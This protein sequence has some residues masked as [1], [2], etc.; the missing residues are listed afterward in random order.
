MDSVSLIIAI[1]HQIEPCFSV[2]DAGRLPVL[3]V[4]FVAS[5]D[6]SAGSLPFLIK[7]QYKLVKITVLFNPKCNLFVVYSRYLEIH[8][9]SLYMLGSIR[10]TDCPI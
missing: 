1:L 5:M 9:F 6:P 10:R 7:F 4:Y 2:K 3:F 8:G